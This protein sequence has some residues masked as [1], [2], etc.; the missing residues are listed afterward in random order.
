MTWFEIVGVTVKTI[1][2]F[3]PIL[4]LSC[5]HSEAELF[6]QYQFVTENFSNYQI[7]FTAL[8]PGSGFE[9]TMLAVPGELC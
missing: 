2:K 4:A 6:G 8:P 9:F 1:E 3:R 5:Y 7:S